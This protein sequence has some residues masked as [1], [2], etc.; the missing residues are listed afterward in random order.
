MALPLPFPRFRP[1]PR[2]I[3]LAGGG[4]PAA[5][6]LVIAD[7]GLWPVAMAYGLGLL[8]LIG[9]DAAQAADDRDLRVTVSPPSLLYIG[10]PDPLRLT[11]GFAGSRR[12]TAVTVLC[13]MG[14]LLAPQPAQRHVL[15][16]G[17]TA[18]ITID[19]H[20]TRR[21]TGVVDRLWFGWVG[22][23]GLVAR[24]RVVPVAA[25]IAIVPDIRAVQTAAISLHFRDAILGSKPQRQQ[26]DGSDY[27]ALREYAPGLDHRSIDWKQSAR[28]RKLYCK[29]FQ[30]ERNHQIVLALD[31]GHLMAEPLAGV[32]RLDHAINAGLLLGHISLRAG[33]RVG[34]FGFDSHERL[35]AEP[36]GGRDGFT[37]LQRLSAEL[38][39]A[40]EET[41]F[42][43]GLTTLL[44]RLTRRS[45]VVL[46]TEFVDTVTAALMIETIGRLA[47]R[48]VVIF[49]TLRDPG[50]QAVI[51]GRPDDD[52]AVARSVIAADMLRD[53]RVVQERLRRLGVH[54]LE[55][56][57]DR[58]GPRL[59]ERY[60]DLK[61]QD[62]I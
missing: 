52:R 35:Y 50:L 8:L 19:L 26:G 36:V 31:S 44:T 42:T 38:D 46:I 13:D 7:P 22:P 30:T 23:Y 60:L 17:A 45:L 12:P 6:L 51:D 21:G 47:A 58:I 53:R 3:A 32:P 49:V 20:P 9:L 61:R 28:H 29:E 40:P 55:A 37:R 4:A 39:Y 48:H 27:A 62:A 54:C 10:D 33:D 18:A 2:A 1:T 25:S 15:P 56:A 14:A 43:L 34:L 11:A 24:R 57:H 5:W 41:N 59:I 16:P